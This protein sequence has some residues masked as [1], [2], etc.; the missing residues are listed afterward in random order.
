ME[1]V[2]KE[3]QVSHKMCNDELSTEPHLLQGLSLRVSEGPARIPNYT[4]VHII[5]P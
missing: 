4:A 5:Q 3:T 1:T 2:R